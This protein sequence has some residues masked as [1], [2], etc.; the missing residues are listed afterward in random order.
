MAIALPT[1]PTTPTSSGG[2][3]PA[4]QAKFDSILQSH[5]YVPPAQPGD[6]A[7]AQN[8][9]SLVKTTAPSGPGFASRVGADINA[10]GA[11]VAE[12]IGNPD[13]N[14]IL[15]GVK[16]AGNAA[17]AVTDVVGEGLTS[18]EHGIES[19]VGKPKPDFK[20][21][22]GNLPSIVEQLSNTKLFREASQYPEHTKVLED[23]LQGGKSLG[24]IANAIL[25]GEGGARGV[26]SGVD[27]IKNVHNDISTYLEAKAP[28]PGKAAPVAPEGPSLT[29]KIRTY[30]AKDNV[31]PRLQ[32][33]ATRLE[34]PANAYKDYAAQAKAAVSDVKADPP[35]A[36]VGENI[37][38]AY[39]HVVQVRRSVGQNMADELT[40]VKDNPVDLSS[41]FPKFEENL[42][43]SG[44]TY[45]AQKGTL[46][47]D[48]QSKMTSLDKDMVSNY[49]QELNKLGA[50]PTAGNLDAF[51]SRVPQE[52][53]L[54]KAQKNIMSVTNAERLIKG[55]LADIRTALTSQPGMEAYAAA[56]RSYANLSNFLDEGSQYLG[57]KTGSGDYARDVSVAKSSAES[58]LSGG[59][60]DWLLKLEGLT[61]YK[62]LDDATL[63]IQAMKDAG[64]TR[65]L[66]LFKTMGEGALSPTSLPFKVLQWG[67]HK[68]VGGVVGSAAEQTQA[69]LESLKAAGTLGAPK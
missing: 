31:D 42:K 41:S 45:D 32:A 50:K 5:N 30:F 24:D 23:W 35:I 14:P 1:A 25:T 64:D 59:K 38:D 40:K 10:R 21:P 67:A 44:L 6:S 47:S 3:S 2:L 60:K 7:P 63:A 11:K 17:G 49:V 19:V 33:S 29:D 54:V 57:A 69:F 66:S 15:S 56:R 52:L 8:W 51:L 62:A 27:A 13:Q 28:P 36:K 43:Q 46:I 68:V 12:E 55:N 61:G 9:R 34:N 53:D 48:G 26:Q 65:G 20:P 16:A 18:L 39:D 4:D 58:I 37:G 22:G